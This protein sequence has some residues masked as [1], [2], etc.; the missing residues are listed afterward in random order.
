M[1]DKDAGPRTPPW[2]PQAKAQ[3]EDKDGTSTETETKAL[4]QVYARSQR[5]IRGAWDSVFAAALPGP[6]TGLAVWSEGTELR[7]AAWCPKSRAPG[8]GLAPSLAVGTLPAGL[9]TQQVGSPPPE[10]NDLLRKPE[11]Q[12]EKN[13]ELDKLVT[14][15]RG[16]V[17]VG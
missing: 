10:K 4:L 7:A 15:L 11:L 6:P 3:D 12:K 13:D 8:G 2:S 17:Y 1:D 16:S 5:S 14:R 9:T